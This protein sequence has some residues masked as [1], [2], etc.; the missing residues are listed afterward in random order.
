[1][2]RPRVAPPA[3]RWGGKVPPNILDFDPMTLTYNLHLYDLW[4][5]PTTLTFDLDL[6]DLDLD[7]RD[8]DLGPPF[9]IQG[10]KLKLYIFLP[11]WPWPLT[12]DLVRDMMVLNVCAKELQSAKRHT[13]THTWTLP[14]ILPLPLMREVITSC[15]LTIFNSLGETELLQDT[16]A[17]TLFQKKCT[18]ISSNSPGDPRSLTLTPR[19][20]S[21]SDGQ[22]SNMQRNPFKY[23]IWKVWTVSTVLSVSVV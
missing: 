22:E 13:G 1:M 11:S 3:S 20:L 8:L 18:L 21:L 4:P 23:P 14:K 5:R 15:Q 6:C 2:K 12:Y 7:P 9:L 17:Y 16:Q 10:W 19:H